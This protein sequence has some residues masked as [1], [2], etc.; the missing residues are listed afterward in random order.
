MEFALR[1]LR[2]GRPGVWIAMDERL[3]DPDLTEKIE[4]EPGRFRLSDIGR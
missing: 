4:V 2:G 1:V 3:W